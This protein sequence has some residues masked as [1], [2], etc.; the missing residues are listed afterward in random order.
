MLDTI[1][2][3][4]RKRA[5]VQHLV[6]RELTS[7]Y[8][9]KTFGFLWALL[10][11]LLFMGVYYL[12]FGRILATRPLSFMLHLFVGV[13]AF[14]LLTTAG[15]QSANCLR[16]NSGLIREIKFPMAALPTSVVIARLFDFA[17]AWL[18]AIPLSIIFHNP[19]TGYWALIPLIIVIQIL[20]VTGFCFLVAYVGVFFADIQNIL[21][22]FFRLWF[23][24]TPILYPLSLVQEKAARYSLLLKLYMLNPM[25]S[26]LEC[27][28]ALTQKAAFP[29]VGQLLYALVIALLFFALGILVFS[30]RQGQLAKY[31]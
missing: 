25:T 22:V 30:R 26:I 11:P 1:R 15:S 16:A 12:V 19:I 27:Y 31:V 13:V 9:T 29:Q 10:D 18:I 28:T 2:D 20:F 7:S 14:R 6:Q 21:G 24:M 23:Y 3:T 8:R 5:V 4:W 17:A